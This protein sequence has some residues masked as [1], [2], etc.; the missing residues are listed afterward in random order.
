MPTL[1]AVKN[2]S[3]NLPVPCI[4]TFSYIHGSTFE[5]PANCRSCSTVVVTTEKV[6]HIGGS[7]QFE[8][9]SFGG[10]PYI[11]IVQPVLRTLSILTKQKFSIKWQFHSSPPDS[12]CQLSNLIILVPRASVAAQLVKNSPTMQ[13]IQ[14]GF[15]SQEDSLEKG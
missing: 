15:L 11:H 3:L 13:E 7:A 10:Q 9:L 1:Y 14:V 8:S 5:D 6:P 12:A 2:L 4:C